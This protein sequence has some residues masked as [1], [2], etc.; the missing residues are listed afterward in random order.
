[1]TALLDCLDFLRNGWKAKQ[2]HA[3]VIY[4]AVQVDDV[5]ISY[6]MIFIIIKK[7]EMVLS[8]N[9]DVCIAGSSTEDGVEVKLVVN[10]Y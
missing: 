8:D 9:E 1:M 4:E 10:F 7:N 2:L 5:I 3:K 6:I